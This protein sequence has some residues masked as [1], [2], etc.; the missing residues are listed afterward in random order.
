M[1]MSSLTGKRIL[2]LIRDGDFAHPGEI[3][4]VDLLLEGLP[5]DRFRRVLDLGCGLGGTAALIAER[6]Y[7]Q[8][9]GVDADPETIAYARRT[10]SGLSFVCASASDVSR[11]VEGPFDAIVMFTAFYCFPD[12]G[13]ALR[14]CRTLAH[15]GSELR[16]FD[17]TTPTWNTGT[18]N[19]CARYA[20]GG[21]WKPLV[22]DQ[23]DGLLE[24][25]GWRATVR[26]D[27]GDD[28]LRWYRELLVKIE[29][30]RDL[31]IQAADERWYAYAY[32]RYADLFAA[33]EQG[34]IGGAIVHAVP[35][36][37]APDEGDLLHVT[38]R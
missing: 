18:R 6:G 29:A 22:L 32:Q 20:R 23:V 13:Q 38:Q 2:S 33:I 17:Y 7:G 12:Q 24:T 16:I 3:E 36:G 35:L 5:C 11:A 31:I 28:F 25:N 26:R 4:A 8:V 15:A 19:F 27:L 1:S 21:H 9:T 10:Y 30:M 14:E 34:T 37:S